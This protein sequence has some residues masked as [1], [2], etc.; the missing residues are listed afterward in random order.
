MTQHFARIALAFVLVA[1]PMLESIRGADISQLESLRKERKFA[2]TELYTGPDPGDANQL[3]AL[4][5]AAIDDVMAM[6]Q[7][8]LA[9]TVRG[10]LQKL[11]DD[12]DLLA[13]ED[14]DQ[15]YIYAIRIWRAA[16]FTEESGLFPVSDERVLRGP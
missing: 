3:V 16:G 6:P 8:Y 1:C 12:V 7:P 13:T 4:V 11:I 15:T 2:P 9:E 5:N 14:R 10:R